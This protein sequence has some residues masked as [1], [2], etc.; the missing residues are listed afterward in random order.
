MNKYSNYNKPRFSLDENCAGHR[1]VKRRCPNCGRK[2]FVA[3]LDW[4]TEQPIDA[5]VLGICDHVQSCGYAD[6][7]LKAYWK[8]HPDR[9]ET[10]T[11]EP[12]PSTRPGWQSRDRYD[13]YDH[14]EFLAIASRLAREWEEEGAEPT[15]GNAD[16]RLN[17]SGH[18]G[19]GCRAGGAYR[20]GAHRKPP[21]GFFLVR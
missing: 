1:Q 9:Y 18:G 10:L 21:H 3:M 4:E 5:A 19:G 6:T 20:R 13:R 12:H 7:D 16:D 17:R 14:S 11:G 2:S 8:Q 15:G